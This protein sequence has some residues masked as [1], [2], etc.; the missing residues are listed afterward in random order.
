MSSPEPASAPFQPDRLFDGRGFAS[1]PATGVVQN[2]AGDRVVYAPANFTRGLY[3]ILRAEK[4]GTWPAAFQQG[5]AATGRRAAVQLDEELTRVGEP[6]LAAMPLETCL[7]FVE[8]YCASHGW[9]VLKLDLADAS[10]HGLVTA[11]LTRSYFVE[12]LNDADEFVD[13]LISGILQG[14][15][16]HI[17]GQELGCLEIA[18][19]RRG[20]PG[21]TFIITAPE[22]LAAIAPLLGSADAETIIARLKA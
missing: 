14:F 3:S 2:P 12:V 15:F 19:T 18:C 13:P 17:S 5:G 8:H 10:E 16:E 20:A 6:A 22:R 11:R 1:D 9:G 4:A 21:C 7:T